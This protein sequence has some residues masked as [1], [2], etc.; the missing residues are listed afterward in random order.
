[1][2]AILDSRSSEFPA[3]VVGIQA[4]VLPGCSIPLPLAP[5][6]SP[7]H[8][9]A[10][11]FPALLSEALLSGPEPYQAPSPLLQTAHFQPVIR[12]VNF[13]F[14]TSLPGSTLCAPLY[15]SVGYL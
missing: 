10:V 9:E 7:Q 3:W 6:L 8:R 15:C 14:R 12:H 1:M 2:T 13:I 11:H 4:G 5:N